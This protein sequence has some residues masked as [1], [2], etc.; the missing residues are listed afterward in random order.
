MQLPLKSCTFLQSVHNNEIKMRVK[1][2][3]N[4]KYLFYKTN[5][6]KNGT[7]H[8]QIMFKGGIKHTRIIR[9]QKQR[10]TFSV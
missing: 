1:R 4:V 3:R 7:F 2:P 5:T 10:H 6:E 8:L 9:A